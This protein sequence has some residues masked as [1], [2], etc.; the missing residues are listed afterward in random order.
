[1]TWGT[2]IGL[3]MDIALG[4]MAFKLARSLEATVKALSVGHSELLKRVET[5]EVKAQ[6]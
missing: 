6:K 3:V 1:M 4:G 2:I 5:L